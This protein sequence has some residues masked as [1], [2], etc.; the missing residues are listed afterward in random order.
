MRPLLWDDPAPQTMARVRSDSQH[1]LFVAIQAIGIKAGIF[2]P[3][4]LVKP[5]E[6]Q[7]RLFP[8]G[9]G[10]LRLT[11]SLVDFR[12]AGP[13]IENVALQLT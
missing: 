2:V 11:E 4:H 5:L 10:T 9:F 7:L 3:E 12:H 8:K 6:Q 13:G 1:F